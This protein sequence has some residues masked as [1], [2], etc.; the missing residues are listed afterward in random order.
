MLYCVVPDLQRIHLL[1]LQSE[2]PYQR[3]ALN[4]LN[5]GNSYAI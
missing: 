2:K 1:P 3:I 4:I 5:I